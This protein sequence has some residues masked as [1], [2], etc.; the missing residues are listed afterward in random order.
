MSSPKTCPCKLKTGARAGLQC[1]VKVK[2]G[3]Y[4]GRHKTCATKLPSPAR[5]TKS[6]RRSP[7]QARRTKSK[8]LSA[9]KKAAIELIINH[10]DIYAPFEDVKEALF[11]RLQATF[12]AIPLNKKDV[13]MLL[14]RLYDRKL[15]IVASAECQRC[16]TGLRGV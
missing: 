6:K 1:G 11:A 15:A 5:R 7:S 3:K 14:K 2:Q 13:I 12:P 9:I 16:E 8:R 4:C 10:T